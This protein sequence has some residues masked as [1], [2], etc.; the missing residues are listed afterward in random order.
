MWKDYKGVVKRTRRLEEDAGVR[1]IRV[2]DGL[3][4]EI[5]KIGAWL[6]QKIVEF[7]IKYLTDLL[8]NSHPFT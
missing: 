4:R 3:G 6:T 1:R 5:N 7:L 8:D 2:L